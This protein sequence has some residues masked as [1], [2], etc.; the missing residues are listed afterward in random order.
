[1][2]FIK[3]TYAAGTTAVDIGAEATKNDF[4]GF[5][6][7]GN[8]VSNIVAAGFL[9]SGVIVFL[10]IVWGG[11]DYLSS[12]GDKGKIE[13]GQKRITAAIIGLAIVASSWAIY[14]LVIY[15]FGINLDNLCTDNPIGN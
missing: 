8:I 5:T 14:Q 15:F 4:F 3:D 10:Y 13:S 2:N 1:M 7:V 11:F 12:G 9:V 6:C